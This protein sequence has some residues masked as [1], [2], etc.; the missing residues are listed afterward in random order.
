MPPRDMPRSG[1]TPQTIF[2]R[3][4]AIGAVVLGAAVLFAYAGGWLSRI[5]SLPPVWSQR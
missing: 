5:V 1:P 4:V 3:L 2:G